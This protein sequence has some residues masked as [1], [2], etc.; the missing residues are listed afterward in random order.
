M[1]STTSTQGGQPIQEE[2]VPIL[3]RIAVTAAD[4][5]VGIIMGIISATLSYYFTTNRGLSLTN[6]GIVWILFGIW[7]AVNDPIY[8]YITDRTKSKLGRR[9][10]YVRYGAPLITISYI[11]CWINWPVTDNQTILFI[12][13]LIA[14][15]FYDTFYTAVASALYVLPFEM[16][17]SNKARGSIFIWKVLFSVI[18]MAFP[19]VVLGFR[20]G[21]NDDTTPF[22]TFQIILAVIVGLI[23]FASS[24]IVK[25]N[26]YTQEEEQPPF[27]KALLSSFK[28]KSFLIFEV[29]SFTVIYVQSALFMGLGY[30]MEEVT[31]VNVIP[32]IVAMLISTIGTLIILVTRHETWGVKKLMQGCL[33]GIS[34]GAIT[35]SFL[36]KNQI[37]ATIAFFLIGLGVAAGFYLIQ[38]QF[39]DVIDYDEIQTGLRREGVYAGVNS[40]VTKPAFSFANSIFLWVIAYYGYDTTLDKGLQTGSAET[41]ILLGWM[42]VPGIL[43]FISFLIMFLYPLAGPKWK[44]QKEKLSKIHHEKEKEYLAKLG[45]KS[46]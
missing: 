4:G 28:N 36:G 33:L 16:A 13:F 44:E 39:G 15:F 25:E 43:L 46:E 5:G 35:L 18:G 27:F 1:Q 6:A 22:V 42:L 37:F 38:I 3:S 19:L 41:G 34:V 23:V 12:H 45:Y 24:Y 17:V 29:L 8:G 31:N 20:P 32:L 2:N 26:H 7:N 14:L 10:P 11:A 21:A 40:L 9:I 30:Y